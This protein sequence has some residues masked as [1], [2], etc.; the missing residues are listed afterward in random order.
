MNDQ[1]WKAWMAFVGDAARGAEEAKKM[2]ARL[3][4]MEV[5]P[6]L[7][8]QWFAAWGAPGLSTASAEQQARELTEAM[9][10]WWGKMGMVPVAQYE[11]LLSHNAKLE[12]KLREA[13]DEI[14]RLSEE[15]G[16]AGREEAKKIAQSLEQTTRE[17]LDAQMQFA[18]TMTAG[19]FGAAGKGGDAGN[20]KS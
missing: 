9:R 14:T 6:E 2:F 7:A 19:L 11:Q 12:A 18:E 8:R 3:T 13:R 16:A 17:I 1:L 5:D 10:A 20:D 4:P 15:L